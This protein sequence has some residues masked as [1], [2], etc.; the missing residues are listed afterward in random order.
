MGV[1][2]YISTATALTLGVLVPLWAIRNRFV[3]RRLPRP[4]VV[5][6][7]AE[8][9][10]IL[11]ASSGIGRALAHR[12]ADRGAK[13]CMVAR[14]SAELE[15]VQL[16]CES[17]AQ[18]PD[19]LFSICSDFTRV[20]DLVTIREG[21]SESEFA[22]LGL[23]LISHTLLARVARSR[24]VDCYCWRFCLAPCPGDCWCAGSICN[25][26]TA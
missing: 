23:T 6:P 3:K 2:Y 5:P 25:C 7:G 19:S 24:Y 16:E 22:A 10:L 12:Y 9:V 21:I 14:R 11:G 17:I 26:N 1:I 13:V 4:E 8:R 18:V 20:E 15:V